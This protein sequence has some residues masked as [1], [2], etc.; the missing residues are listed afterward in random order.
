[1]KS[2]ACQPK[3]KDVF[4]VTC[5]SGKLHMKAFYLISWFC[6]TGLCLVCCQKDYSCENSKNGVNQLPIAKAGA[7]QILKL[8]LDS[9]FLDASGS[10]DPDGQITAYEWS[11][12]AGPSGFIVIDSHSVRTVMKSVVAGSYQVQLLITDNEGATAKDTLEINVE[13]SSVNIPPVAIAGKDQSFY[14]P[15]DSAFLDGS[16]SF[17]QDGSIVTY[18]WMQLDGPSPA[19]IN[20]IN[21]SYTLVTGLQEGIYHFCLKVIDNTGLTSEDTM[22]LQVLKPITGSGGFTFNLVWTCKSRCDDSDVFVS[23]LEGFNLF[24]DPNIPMEV[25]V[26]D[27]NIWIPVFILQYP[28]TVGSKYFYTITQRTLFVYR[29]PIAGASNYIGKP[30]LV[31]V[32]FI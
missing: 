22:Q 19:H 29:A 3:S 6:L 18:Q 26:M 30:V 14:L 32:R 13:S 4:I 28:L 20:K 27:N 1:V 31:K 8:P 23:I 16:A 15:E 7:D 12:I 2:L 10:L 21:S 11:V 24:A 25:Y 9:L 17:D 5:Y